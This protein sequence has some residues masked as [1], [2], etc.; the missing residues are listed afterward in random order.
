MFLTVILFLGVVFRFVWLKLIVNLALLVDLLF[1]LE[2]ISLF[3][4]HLVL[5]DL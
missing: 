1:L 3:G 4:M 2:V 5:L